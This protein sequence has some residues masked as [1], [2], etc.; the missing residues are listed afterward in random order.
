MFLSDG[1]LIWTALQEFNLGIINLEEPQVS[2]SL[3][4]SL[5]YQDTQD[6]EVK[7][8][9]HYYAPQENFVAGG[10]V[11]GSIWLSVSEESAVGLSAR[12]TGSS[13]SEYVFTEKERIDRFKLEAEGTVDYSQGNGSYYVGVL[14]SQSSLG[15]SVDYWSA[16]FSLGGYVSIPQLLIP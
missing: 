12:V 15:S 13:A 16:Y 14:Y 8:R 7:A 3:I 1:N 11:L 6:D 5:I 9:A 10:G 2:V 4:G